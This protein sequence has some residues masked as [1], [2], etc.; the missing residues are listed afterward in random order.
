M[1]ERLF[2]FIQM[3]FPWILGPS[4]GRYLL[5]AREDA[6]PERVIVLGV[7]GAGRGPL[8]RAGAAPGGPTRMFER[9]GARGAGRTATPEPAPVSTTRATVIDPVSL[10]AESQARAWLSNL[11]REHEVATAVAIVNRVLHFHRVA[12]ADPYVHEVSPSQALVIRAGWGEGEQVANG[13]WAHASEI[14]VPVAGRR[15]GGSQRRSSGD[16]SAA[17]RPQERLAALMGARSATL[18]CEELVLRAR[19]DADQGRWAHAA[20]E[21]RGAFA[22]AVPELRAESRQDLAVRLAELETLGPLVAEQA[23]RAA[24]A[25][26]KPDEEVIGHALGRL[27]AALRARTATGFSLR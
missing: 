5:R 8:S 27:E 23:E 24:A 13:D 26:G 3:E 16:R 14:P 12:S 19:L 22:A 11:D 21:L 15:A 10:S 1:P 6:D 2:V 4:E 25:T 9:W 18:L 20:L 7:L 17:L